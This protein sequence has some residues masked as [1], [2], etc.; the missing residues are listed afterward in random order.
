VALPSGGPFV[1]LPLATGI[2]N[3]TSEIGLSVYPNPSNGNLF[4]NF[5]LEQAQNVTVQITDLNG[6]VVKEL[7]NGNTVNGKQNLNADLSELSNG[8][9]L[10]R[11]TT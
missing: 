1:A 9:Y 11:I 6:R 3:V 8:M 10:A 5:E 4:I 7:M 2:S